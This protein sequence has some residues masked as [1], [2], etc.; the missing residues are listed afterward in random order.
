MDGL[1]MEYP[2]TLR[3]LFERASTYFPRGEVVWRAADRSV[4]REDYAA[5]HGRVL[6]LA[7][8]LAAR[9]LR[10][11]D[12][13]ATL[14]WNHG[15]HLEAYFAVPL[16]GGVLHT[17]NPRLA[18]ADIAHIIGDAQDRLLLVDDVLLP[19]WEKV[20]PLASVPGVVV[21]SD[22]AQGAPGME[23]YAALLAAAPAGF[24]PP[25][26]AE[27]QAAGLC[28]TSG[29]TGRPKGVLY[30]HRSMVLHALTISLADALGVSHQDCV[31]PVVPMFH[32]NAWGLPFASVMAGAKQV[33]PGPHLDPVSLL[34]LVHAERVTIA[35]G[36]PTVWLGVLQALDQHPGR[37]DTS[38]LR[39]IVI[40]GAAAPKALIEAYGKRHGLEVVHAWGMTEM[41]PVGTVCRLKQTLRDRP[42]AERLS[43]RA[44]Q[45]LPVP[46][47]ETR[48][49]S[50]AGEVPWDG[51]SMGE[52]HVRG[53]WIARRYF[54]DTAE[55]SKFTAD[56]WFRTGDR[57]LP[58][59][60][61]IRRR[62]RA[63]PRL[64]PG[65]PRRS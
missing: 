9:G 42:E 39:Q 7:S 34:D 27:G 54:N 21:M 24:E 26:L 48:V 43:I 25:P 63:C 51:T 19:V 46:F 14:A 56:G 44:T 11:G 52:L 1:M 4:L 55:D 3:H 47:V 10:P 59:P 16:A 65:V 49:I 45:G 32:V 30:S 35:A 36:V 22:Q 31:M 28:Y 37:W 18:P 57:Y 53:P 41:S 2:L 15:R 40:G 50:D 20:K 17:V 29:T 64:R 12:R 8:A 61:H 58:S 6:R 23:D 38:S 5:F 33:F 62:R 13:V 60:C